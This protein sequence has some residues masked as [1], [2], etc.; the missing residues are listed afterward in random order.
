MAREPSVTDEEYAFILNFLQEQDY[1][2]SKVQ[3]V[4]QRENQSVSKIF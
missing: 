2:I 4:P 3:K 1:D